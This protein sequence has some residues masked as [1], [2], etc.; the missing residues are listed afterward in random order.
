MQ[1]MQKI[2]LFHSFALEIWLIKKSY[3]L[4]TFWT[5]SQQQKFSQIWDLSRNTV[6][7]K[8]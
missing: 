2:K 8:N 3:N 4:G 7:E 5:I 6:N 1:N